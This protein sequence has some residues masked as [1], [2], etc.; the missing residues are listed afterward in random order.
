[1]NLSQKPLIYCLFFASGFAG[2]VYEVLWMKELGLLF[3]NT[4]YAASATLA[5]FFLGI[6][7]GSLLLGR[8]A[9]DSKNPLRLY[10][11]LEIA[12]SVT[13]LLYFVLLDIY[14]LSYSTLFELFEPGTAEFIGVKFV[15][16]L[17]VL[18]PPA[19]FMGGTLPVMS[20]F[21]TQRQDEIGKT[22]SLLYAINTFG[23]TCGALA[24]GFYLPR[25]LG[26]TQSYFVAIS[27]TTSVAVIAWLL[28][29]NN[30]ESKEAAPV[31]HIR[32]DQT[33]E[34]SINIRLIRFLAF[35]SGF[36]ALGLE[37][38]WTRM[39]AQVLQNSV[40]TFSIILV[41]FLLA[42]SF[43]A[44]V[45]RFLITLRSSA[46]IILFMLLSVSGLL[47]AATPTSF[48][49]LTD[50]LSYFGKG[51]SWDAYILKVFM[52][53]MLTMFP[54]ILVLGSL[55]PYLIRLSESQKLAASQTVGD[56]A[57][58]NT[59]GAVL[60]SL[61]AGFVLLD[62]LGLWSSVQLIAALYLIA[63]CTILLF[64]ATI[65]VAYSLVP[66][67]VLI[68]SFVIFYAT[69]KPQITLD[70]EKKQETLIELWEGSG[71]TV[72]V[73]TRKNSLRVKVNN[74]YG[75]GGSGD[76]KNEERQSHLPLLIHGNA[77]SVFYL[78][79][80]TG[81]TAGAAL[82]H[83]DIEKIVVTE[84]LPDVVKAT[85]K[86]FEPY[87]HGLYTDKRSTV[88][89]EDGRNYLFG[90]D[91]IFDLIIADLFIPWKAGTGSLYTVEHFENAKDHLNNGGIYAQ[92]LPLF[93]LTKNEFD[94]IARTMLNVFPQVTLWRSKFQSRRPIMLIAGHKNLSQLDMLALTKQLSQINRDE[95]TNRKTGSIGKEAAPATP[96][97]VLLHY[98]GNLTGL[99]DLFIDSP[100]NTD[101]LPHIEYNS[102]KSIV[103]AKNGQENWFIK[104]SLIDFYNLILD[105][106]PP[107][108]DPYLD[109][110]ESRYK[111]LP[112]AGFHLHSARVF[113]SN[114]DNN[115]YQRAMNSF[116]KYNIS[117]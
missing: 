10:A 58:V 27:L 37:V 9:R 81:I 61:I 84:L 109:D 30:I 16:A 34:G 68:L 86:H 115:N 71:A 107:E 92:W 17:L 117:N 11:I 91:E 79:M 97:H 14:H 90:T 4:S 44:A 48:L 49:A 65:K 73:V 53:A 80:G 60:G 18:F 13:A 50:G 104:D 89:A 32:V 2:L 111:S 108:N 98:A 47:I 15:L 38:I 70:A 75:L 72:A 26:F 7:G 114:N 100:I 20:Q 43:G 5:A 106:S 64:S 102:P 99:D 78:G 54:P 55:F 110:I 24:A 85:K 76:H 6:A 83:P 33:D 77:K 3:G 116:N 21:L 63:A 41:V 87:L 67:S 56:L 94:T 1:M 25:L 12:V 113:K 52:L 23:A 31:Q 103:A 66:A 8:F 105:L 28:S 101:N 59:I 88:I 46:T 51:V 93:Q 69:E 36:S 35:F 19:F 112:I 95:P 39:F 42:L 82:Q 45:A 22:A 96:N 40:Y 29:R 57:F 74:F 62:V